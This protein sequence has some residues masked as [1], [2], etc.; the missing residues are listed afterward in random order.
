MNHYL[1]Q[2]LFIGIFGLKLQTHLD[3]LKLVYFVRSNVSLTREKLVAK[4]YKEHRGYWVKDTISAEQAIGIAIRIWLML[5]VDE[6]PGKQ[7]LSEYVH[8]VFPQRQEIPDVRPFPLAFN[9]YNLERIGGFD[10]IWTDCIQEHL[11]LVVDQT[12]KELKIFH[13]ASFLQN[14][15]QCPDRYI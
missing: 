10:I 12:Q 11:S 3:L 7:T 6:W 1:N 2:R 14:Y 13:L 8:G 5:D 4:L 9:G 15:K